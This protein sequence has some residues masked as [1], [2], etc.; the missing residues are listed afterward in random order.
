M[1]Q[2]S[3]KS[4][5]SLLFIISL[6]AVALITLSLAG[7][8]AYTAV[9]EARLSAAKARVEQIGTVLLMA[10]MKA[11]QAGLGPAPESYDSLLKSYEGNAGYGLSEHDRFV[12]AYMLDAFGPG[13][14][15]D[16]AATR[17]ADS[18]GSHLQIYY[19]PALGQT[20]VKRSHHYVLT[21]GALSEKNA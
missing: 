4:H 15:F 9:R 21:A 11:E 7:G 17:F 2:P 10:E 8:A 5:T 19:F 1:E 14:D 13:R 16:F 20:D 6:V 3:G 12:L 18:G